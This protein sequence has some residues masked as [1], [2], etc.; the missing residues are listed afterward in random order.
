MNQMAADG[1]IIDARIR[2]L[3]AARPEATAVAWRNG[4][5]IAVGDAG[6]IRSVCDLHTDIIALNGEHLVP[7][8]VDAHFHPLAGVNSTRGGVDLMHCR[9]LDEA[10]AML[11]EEAARLGDGDWVIAY[12]LN[13]AVF[14]NGNID[15]RLLAEA[16][17]HVPAMITL[18]DHHAAVAT[19]KAL[20][21][22]GITGPVPLAGNSEIICRNGVPTGELREMPA[23]DLVRKAIPALSEKE[24]YANYVAAFRGWNAL[25]LTGVHAMDGTPETLDL[26]RKLEAHGDLTMRIVVPMT[27]YPDTSEKEMHELLKFRDERGKNWRCGAAKFFID[28]T[29]D[30]GT[31]WLF[32]PD[33]NGTGL[34]PYWP[35]PALYAKAVALFAQAGFQCITH[36]IGDRAVKVALDAYKAAGHAPGIRHRIEHIETLRD[37]ELPRFAAE[38]VIASMQPL[39]ADMSFDS[40]EPTWPAMLGPARA[41]RAWRYGDL[42]RTGA[43]VPLG[44]DWPIAPADPRLSMASAQMRR[45][46][47]RPDMRAYGPEQA[48]SGLQALEG[49]TIEAARSVGEAAFSGAIKPGYRA[50]FTGFLE[51]PVTCAPERLPKNPLT[52]TMVGGRVVHRAT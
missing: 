51:D 15:G 5:I 26:L 50:D 32:E 17:G 38:A 21:H 35:D 40:D 8:L 48:F 39:H 1:A 20:E 43:T 33:R 52:I 18:Y 49:Y 31:A 6:D 24:R 37:E 46:P 11:A 22:A 41:A 25:G 4:E 10:R 28:G 16:V 14:P 19:P 30:G 23:M 9:T 47:W 36:A 12:G 3:D 29:V 44:S 13:Y 42:R 27:I 2:T 45:P 7:G 34:T